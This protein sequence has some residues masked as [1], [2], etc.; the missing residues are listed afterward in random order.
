M[1]RGTP[2]WIDL[3]MESA[4]QRCCIEAIEQAVLCSAHDVSDGGMAVAL[5]ECCIGGEKPLGV[6]IESRE[7]IRGDALLFSE[8]QSRIIVSVKEENLDKLREIAARHAVPMQVIGTV[9]GTRFVF[10][11]L[12]QVSVEELKGIW[13][14]GLAAKLN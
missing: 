5:A 8:S 1:T 10:Q 12:V 6:R 13:S 9:G 14:S 11:P 7:M 3:K 4:V 2:P